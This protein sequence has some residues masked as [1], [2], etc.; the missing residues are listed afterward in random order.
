MTYQSQILDLAV[1]EIPYFLL[2]V[3]VNPAISHQPLHQ[4]ILDIRNIEQLGNGMVEHL[5][6]LTADSHSGNVGIRFCQTEK[7][8]ALLD[9][10]GK[11]RV[12]QGRLHLGGV[13]VSTAIR[14][15]AAEKI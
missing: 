3:S 15:E 4:V 9:T 13:K 11:V 1:E 2:P 7:L 8:D 12:G 5:L 14:V 6:L 10:D